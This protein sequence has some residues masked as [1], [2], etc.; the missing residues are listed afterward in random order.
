MFLRHKLLLLRKHR[1]D[2]RSRDCNIHY[3]WGDK[4]IIELAHKHV[5]VIDYEDRWVLEKGFW[6]PDIRPFPG[7]APKIYVRRTIRLS[8]TA[9]NAMRLRATK[10]VYLHR[11][12]MGLAETD[13]AS[14]LIVDH[15][16]NDGLNNTR[17]NL[18][19]VNK[20]HNGY[21]MTD[22][23]K[24]VYGYRGIYQRS[25]KYRDRWS[26]RISVD[27][28]R[29]YLGTFDTKIEAARAYDEAAKTY[30]GPFGHL[31]FPDWLGTFT[32]PTKRGV[33]Q[34]SS[35]PKNASL[36]SSTEP[37]PSTLLV[38]SNSKSTGSWCSNF[39]PRKAV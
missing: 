6:S 23:K 8:D 7:E 20:S 2:M 26:A 17:S 39:S 18:R 1:Y 25:G 30:Y 35:T 29:I 16:D 24:S 14:E 12:I 9:Q 38:G 11:E 15:I 36:C 34:C 37:I 31:N 13:H 33:F 10:K 3:P 27:G 21:N 28:T 5:T 22:R 4:L 19:I 32:Q